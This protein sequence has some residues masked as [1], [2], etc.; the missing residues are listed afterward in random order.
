MRCIWQ[1]NLKKMVLKVVY[2]G[3]KSHPSHELYANMINPEYGF[4]GMM[5]LTLELWT[6]PMN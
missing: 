5:T 6:K 3:L 4:G 1:K 2:P